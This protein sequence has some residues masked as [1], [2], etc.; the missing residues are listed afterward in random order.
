M[1]HPPFVHPQK[2]TRWDATLRS[3]PSSRQGGGGIP[4]PFGPLSS[5]NFALQGAIGAIDWPSDIR[6]RLAKASDVSHRSQSSSV[7]GL[8]MAHGSSKDAVSISDQFQESLDFVTPLGPL[9]TLGF[10]VP[11]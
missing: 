11:G 1:Q 3:P 6:Q 10:L 9:L 5:A 4:G 8:P 2:R 7:A